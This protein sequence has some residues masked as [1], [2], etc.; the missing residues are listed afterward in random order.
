[1]SPSALQVSNLVVVSKKWVLV[2]LSL[3]GQTLVPILRD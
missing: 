2:L 3:A 1:M